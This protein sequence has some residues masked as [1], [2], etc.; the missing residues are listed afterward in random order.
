MRFAK[1]MHTRR[2]SLRITQKQLAEKVGVSV[3]QIWRWETGRRVPNIYEAE[4]IAYSL[5][6]DLMD[7]LVSQ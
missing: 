4:A 5:E 2:C 1:N 7:L 6:V 3:I